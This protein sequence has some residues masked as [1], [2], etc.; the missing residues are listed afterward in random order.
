MNLLYVSEGYK[1]VN[2][3]LPERTIRKPLFRE[4]GP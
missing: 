4:I 3:S 2:K 1:F